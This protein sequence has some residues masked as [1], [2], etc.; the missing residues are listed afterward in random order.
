MW[1]NELLDW[2]T[3]KMIDSRI[4]LGFMVKI[5]WSSCMLLHD[6]GGWPGWRMRREYGF[7]FRSNIKVWKEPFVATL[8]Q[9]MEDSTV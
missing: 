1:L 4:A 5:S 7:S 9:W 2:G 6:T 3:L 8:L